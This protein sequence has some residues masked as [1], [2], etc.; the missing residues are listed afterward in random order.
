MKKIMTALFV[1]LILMLSVVPAFAVDSPQA[2]SFKYDVIVIPTEGG[3]GSYQ[4]TTD[5]DENGN[6]HVVLTP[7]VKPGYEFDHWEIEGEYTTDG[8][9]TDSR[10]E[11]TI[12]SDIKVTPYFRDAQSGTVATGTVAVDH[13]GTSPQTGDMSNVIP[14]A[15]IILSIAACGVASLKL[16]KSR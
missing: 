13:S 6:Q 10:L 1:M 11:L 8:K 9:L 14:Y 15:I 4:F 12:H 3:D 5:I 7:I 2:T 16:V